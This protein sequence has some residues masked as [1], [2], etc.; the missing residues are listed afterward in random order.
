MENEN[1]KMVHNFWI[2]SEKNFNLQSV[3]LT[4]LSFFQYKVCFSAICM[5]CKMSNMFKVNNEDTRIHKVNN[6]IK[7]K[8]TT[9]VVLAYLLL[10][11]NT[12]HYLFYIVFICVYMCCWLWSVNCWLGLFFVVLMLC[13]CCNQFRQ[14]LGIYGEIR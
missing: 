13:A 2:C 4:F 5:L 10:T 8:D 7:N 12:F 11:L 6:R 9:A 3:K 1:K 14:S